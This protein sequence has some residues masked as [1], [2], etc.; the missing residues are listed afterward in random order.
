MPWAVARAAGVDSLPV[1]VKIETARAQTPTGSV[2]PDV[3]N[4]RSPTSGWVPVSLPDFW[5]TRWPTFDGV[6]W[7]RVTWRQPGTDVPVALVIDYLNMAGA[8]YLNGTLMRR[9][10]H[11]LEPLSREWNTPRYL[12]LPAE[13]LHDG[14]NTML[15]RVSGM[16]QYQGGLGPVALGSPEAMHTRYEAAVW[17]RL[18]S[19]WFSLA[20]SVTLS[21]FFLSMWLMRRTEVLYGWFAAMLL[22]WS[23]VQVNQT[24]TGT[25]PLSSTDGWEV[26]NTIALLAYSALYTIFILRLCGRR[27]PR[28]E[29]ALWCAVALASGVLLAAPHARIEKVRDVLF[30]AQALHYF[31]TSLIFLVFACRRGN[32]EHRILAACVAIFVVAGYHD[33][34]TFLGVLHDNLYFTGL[35]VQILMICMA[36]VLG[37]RHMMN[38]KR[39][40]AFNEDLA[41]TVEATQREL[42]QTLYRQHQLEVA[43]ARL[44][45][46]MSFAHNLHD[47]LGSALV[48]SIIALERTPQAIPPRRFLSI[49][50]EL[51]DDLRLIIDSTT[52]EQHGEMRLAD[53]IASQRHRFTRLFETQ[54]AECKWWLSGLEQYALPSARSLDVMRILQEA[55]TNAFKHSHASRIEVEIHA[56]DGLMLIV[57]DN[58]E[59]FVDRGN[60]CLGTGMSSMRARAYRL[61]ASLDISSTPGATVITLAVPITCTEALA[62]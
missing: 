1:I 26:A 8:I 52:G 57:R 51:R 56:N 19:Q 17:M 55:L 61:G 38:L 29:R 41:R 10:A 36:L 23:A 48:G 9:D 60:S 21:C 28:Y 47:G 37:H 30:V 35:T 33:L 32:T 16:A 44:N 34:L 62:L 39:I 2:Q 27:W 11:L 18:T 5:S 3:R 50:K 58:G 43:H 24:A 45:E 25:W 42:T 7:Y 40:E 20:V 6:V 22:A 4:D 59:G 12:L 46:R 31:A 54:G 53:L 13:L 15:F 14:E 49:L